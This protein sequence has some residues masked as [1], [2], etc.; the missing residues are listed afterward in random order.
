MTGYKEHTKTVGNAYCSDVRRCLG[1]NRTYTKDNFE[2]IMSVPLDS[3]TS[4]NSLL[5]AYQSHP[6]SEPQDCPD[7][8]VKMGPHEIK[9]KWIPLGDYLIVHLKRY[10]Y[11]KATNHLSFDQQ[12]KITPFEFESN[13]KHWTLFGFILKTGL[14][15]HGGHYTTFFR[16]GSFFI[17]FVFFYFNLFFPLGEKFY[18]FDDK[19]KEV[20]L[21][22]TT[23]DLFVHRLRVAY[24]LL[25]HG[26]DA[27]SETR[28][29]YRR[30]LFQP[31][32][33][34]RIK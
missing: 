26:D 21:R 31:E 34:G 25:W 27:T 14:S 3:Y 4:M 29:S 11:D 15:Y 9:T 2:T 28:Q 8:G 13:G 16:K 23:Y 1:C 33:R 30:K 22:E 20:S 5:E 10:T 17:L 6:D 24:I 12:V 18:I 32:E 7:C 19:D